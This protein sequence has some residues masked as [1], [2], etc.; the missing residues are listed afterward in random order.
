MRPHVVVQRIFARKG[1]PA[2][3]AFVRLL[4]QVYSPYVLGP[5]SILP[6]A[7][8]T[9]VACEWLG[10][11]VYMLMYV[12]ILLRFE[13]L[14]AVLAAELFRLSTCHYFCNKS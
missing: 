12:T 11:C 5:F 3:T 1:S 2:N 13:D 14:W 6:E 9:Q 7:G 4:I 8:I 10:T